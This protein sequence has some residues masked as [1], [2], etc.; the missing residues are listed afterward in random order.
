MK[1]DHLA[2]YVEDLE[3]AKEFFIRFFAAETNEEYYNP[4]TGLR[5]YF[6]SFTGGSR[7]EIMTRPGL[8]P[9]G[10]EQ[11]FT[12]YTHLAFSAGS[13]DR[14]DQLTKEL[15]ENGYEVLS[16]PRLTGDGYYESCICGPEGNQIEITE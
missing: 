7:L 10:Q 5:T 1:L 13:R 15:A 16:G 4:Q 6:L 8:L 3:G 12:G 9:G 14:V 2:M 11:F